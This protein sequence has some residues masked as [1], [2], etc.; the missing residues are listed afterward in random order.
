MRGTAGMNNL[1]Y[2]TDCAAFLPFLILFSTAT[3]ILLLD[4]FSPK[5]QKGKP[6]YLSL[7][8]TFLAFI[9]LWKSSCYRQLF[10]SMIY[11][12]HYATFCNV[13][14]L[15]AGILVILLSIETVRH[16]RIDY[17]E[18]YA[19]LLYSMSGMILMAQAA[20]L[21]VLFLGLE[22]LSMSVYIL[23]GMPKHELQANEASL[24]YFLLGAFA[25][26]FLLYG[27][28][29][30]YGAIGSLSF[31]CI[32]DYLRKAELISNPYLL[33]G[34]ALLLVGFGFKMALVPF[35]MWTPDVYEGAPTAITAYMA[36]G[37]KAAA[38]AAFV[39]VFWMA[40]PA[41]EPHWVPALWILAALTM[42]VGNI[43]ALV[44][45]NIKRMLAYS[46]IAH[47]GYILV[48]LVAGTSEG[49]SSMLLYLL[50]YTFMNVGAFGVVALLQ[51]SRWVG[52]RVE[53]FQGLGFTSPGLAVIMAIFLFSLAG[54]PP[55][56]GFVAKFFVFA[57]AI[58]SG[59]TWLVIIAVVNS[60][61]AA[62]YYLR[63]VVLM[64]S[65]A[66]EE[67]TSG[68]VKEAAFPT[69]AFGALVIAV[70]ATLQIGIFPQPFW[71]MAR[72]SIT[73]LL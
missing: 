29:F 4:A 1:R 54:V 22:I 16:D 24:K 33:L 18:Y 49:L 40:L 8:A 32:A 48:A 2:F 21:I 46:S 34:T 11:V 10:G 53:D 28:T 23:V 69:I 3:L 35:H 42:T 45:N 71:E 6:A 31:D 43:V 51:E 36:V 17:G 61:I 63:V 72:S 60:V 73:A 47:A 62:Y 15:L 14:F 57:S 37:V 64:Y 30:I 25:S 26:G 55:T 67:Q 44:Q 20:N 39:R 13:L 70:W 12:D 56:A 19:L 68:M 7:I 66:T 59:L 27:L 65:Q 9:S 58:N 41:I 52:E 38:F 5:G 50:A